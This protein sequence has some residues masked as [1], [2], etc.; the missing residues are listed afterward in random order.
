MDE[1]SKTLQDAIRIT[2]AL[3]IE[4]VWVDAVCIIQDDMNDWAREASRMGDVYKHAYLTIA[5]TTAMSSLDGFLQ[6]RDPCFK[7]SLGF[8]FEELQSM[9]A[10]PETNQSGTIHFR[11]PPE[12]AILD[13]LSECK[14]NQRGW[15]LQEKLLSTRILYFTKDV[16][17]YECVTSQQAE[18]S[19][20]RL[21]ERF[22]LPALVADYGSLKPVDSD[23]QRRDL[24]SDWYK[25]VMVYTER[26]ITHPL[27]KL[28]ALQ[29]IAEIYRRVIDDDYVY[30]L[31]KSDLYMG[32]LW[33]GGIT[34][35][36]RHYRAPSWSWASLDGVVSWD[37]SSFTPG[38]RSLISILNVSTHEHCTHCEET[39]GAQLEITAPLAL[40]KDVLLACDF[41]SESDDFD[42]EAFRELEHWGGWEHVGVFETDVKSDM[43]LCLDGTEMMLVA[44]KDETQ[45]VQAI[46]IQSFGSSNHFKRIGSFILKATY[47][48]MTEHDWDD[49]DFDDA[50]KVFKYGKRV[51]V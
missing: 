42:E 20:Y 51:L 24:L 38:W 25:I 34:R 31:W 16:L 37:E 35:Y 41:S 4:Y 5:S 45:N 10:Q 27:D 43:P 33:H 15:T 1:L 23:H 18:N 17:Y 40:L 36:Q 22:S 29:G 48:E 2:R 21:P 44:E 28:P 26:S 47:G 19:G 50:R 9:R 14:W 32:L 8:H 7:A 11:Y 13:D 3:G 49:R 46:I 6:D 30:G 12:R 39:V